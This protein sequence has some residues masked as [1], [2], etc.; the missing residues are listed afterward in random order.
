M[1]DRA[2]PGAL[3]RF[4]PNTAMFTRRGAWLYSLASLAGTPEQAGKGSWNILSLDSL[5]GM[6]IKGQCGSARPLNGAVFVDRAGD[7]V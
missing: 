4:L 3:R 2:V 1:E 7:N 6:G 5:V